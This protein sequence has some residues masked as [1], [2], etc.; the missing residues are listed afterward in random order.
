MGMVVKPFWA[1]LK[2]GTGNS[3][4]LLHVRL[5]DRK[6]ERGFISPW[7]VLAKVSA[8]FP[9]ASLSRRASWP[10]D[11]GKRNVRD[12]GSSGEYEAL[13]LRTKKGC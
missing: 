4:R 8:D 2:L 12:L 5:G 1:V 13:S 7:V 9:V 3:N 6:G 10:L 11:M